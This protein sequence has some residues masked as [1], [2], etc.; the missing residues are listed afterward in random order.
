MPQFQYI[1]NLALLVLLPILLV[2]FLVAKR[3]KKRALLLMGQPSLVKKLFVKQKPYAALIRFVFIFFSMALLLLAFANLRLPSGTEKINKKGVDIMVALDVSKSMLAKDVTPNRLTRAKQFLS[4]L[5]TQMGSN[6]MGMVVFAGKAYLQMPLTSDLAA[7]KMYINASDPQSIP[8]QGTVLEEALKMSFVSFNT[9]EKKH[10]TIIL[11]SDGEDHEPGAED[12]AK[13][14]AAQGVTILTIGIG[15]LQGAT[16]YDEVNNEVK[17]DAEGNIVISKLNE[18]TLKNIAKNGNGAYHHFE[19]V[20]G[21][22]S[23]VNNIIDSMS[24]SSYKGNSLTLFKSLYPYL[25]G[26]AFLLLIIEMLF[27]ENKKLR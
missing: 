25:I 13:E 16:L 1:F 7:A 19:T 20:D 24:K 17:K 10:K 11:I 27:N 8:T 18:T 6:R 12:V 5:T 21:T 26:L 4:K 2:I 15:S 22:V 3:R 9:E 14:L 23:F